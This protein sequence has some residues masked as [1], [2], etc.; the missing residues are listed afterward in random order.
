MSALPLPVNRSGVGPGQIE[1]PEIHRVLRVAEEEIR[2]AGARRRL[3]RNLDR[4]RVGEL[5]RRGGGRRFL[6]EGVLSGLRLPGRSGGDLRSPKAL[7]RRGAALGRR[8]GR[9]PPPPRPAPA[10]TARSCRSSPRSCR[11]IARG[12]RSTRHRRWPERSREVAGGWNARPGS[13]ICPMIGKRADRRGREAR[14]PL[15]EVDRILDVPGDDEVG[16]AGTGVSE[17]EA[18]KSVIAHR[19]SGLSASS[20]RRHRRAV[21]PGAHRP[22]DVLARRSAAEGPALREVRRRGSG[23]PSRPSGLAP[24][25]RHRGRACRGT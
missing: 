13:M 15:R 7:A 18:M 21:Q 16:V 20:E 11:A 3:C 2:L 23:G 1:E 8:C 10:A 9:P 5:G 14:G 22:E 19:C 25:V 4:D 24:T 12:R 17:S 6:L